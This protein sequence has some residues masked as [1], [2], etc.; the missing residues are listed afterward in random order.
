M[1]RSKPTNI[2]KLSLSWSSNGTTILLT[3]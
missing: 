1:F 2:D 3:W